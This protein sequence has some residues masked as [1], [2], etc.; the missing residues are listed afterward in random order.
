MISAEMLV[1]LMQAGLTKQ[2]AN[3]VTADVVVNTCMP[4]E[5]KVLIAEANNQVSEMQKMVSDLKKQYLELEAKIGKINEV[6]TSV[7]EAR[8]E[9]GTITDEK[10]RNTIALY[11][12]LLNMNKKAGASGD[13]CINNA[14]YVTYAYLGG[15]ARRITDWKERDE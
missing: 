8:E 5:G 11:A 15:Q 12:A 1:R 14:G 2:Q 10:G 4:E 13:E 9:Y 3:S 6:L 7:L